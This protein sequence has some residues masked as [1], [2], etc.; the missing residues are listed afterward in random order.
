MTQRDATSENAK[1]ADRLDA[2]DLPGDLHPRVLLEI[3]GLLGL[4]AEALRQYPPSATEPLEYP[5]GDDVGC[6]T[7]PSGERWAVAGKVARYVESLKS[8]PAV[9]ESISD[10]MYDLQKKWD[11]EHRA[12]EAQKEA[13]IIERCAKVCEASG[14]R[15]GDADSYWGPEYAKRIRSMNAGRNHG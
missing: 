13:E 10:P 8:A 14:K 12:R 4:A 11:E 3:Q 2:L 9:G 15:I 7:L 5:R 6:V 1:L